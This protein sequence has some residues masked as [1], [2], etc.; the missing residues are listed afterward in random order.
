MKKTLIIIDYENEWVEPNSKYYVGNISDQISKLRELVQFCRKKGF[1]IIFTRHIEPESKEAFVPGTSKVDIISDTGFQEKDL[2]ITKQSVSPFFQT[3]LE[4]KLKQLGADH[5][6]VTGILT[7]LCVRSCVS[8]AY[9]RDYK[10]TVITDT[11]VAFSDDIHKFTLKDLKDTRPEIE[12]L[13]VEDF[14][15]SYR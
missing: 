7:N 5:L 11:C 8:D 9:D 12:F 15:S 6:V 3:E 2:L 13:T 14:I 10:I 1:P 4:A